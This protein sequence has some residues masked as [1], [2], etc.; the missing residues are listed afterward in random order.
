MG[1]LMKILVQYRVMIVAI[2]C[3]HKDPTRRPNMEE[4]VYE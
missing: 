3:L 2:A 4:I 1:V